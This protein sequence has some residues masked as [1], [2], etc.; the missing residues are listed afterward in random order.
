MVR[1]ND[2]VVADL[3]DQHGL[4]W[5]DPQ[6]G[7]GGHRATEGEVGAA[8]EAGLDQRDGTLAP[9]QPGSVAPQPRRGT[10]AMVA[11]GRWRLA[12]PDDPGLR[13]AWRGNQRQLRAQHPEPDIAGH[14]MPVRARPPG[15][16]SCWRIGYA[17]SVRPGHE[18]RS[19]Q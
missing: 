10:A 11:R 15:G 6:E 3:A 4:V 8:R 1:A 7:L 17:T 19:P 12:A 13:A 9:S 5:F 18:E 2:A 16:I 14:R